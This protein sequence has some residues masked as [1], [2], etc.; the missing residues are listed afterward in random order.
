MPGRDVFENEYAV[1]V[2]E[3]LC[4]VLRTE[5]YPYFHRGFSVRAEYAPAESRG[6][7]HFE[8]QARKIRCHIDVQ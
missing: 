6:W 8:A 2:G 1:V 4:A 3:R 7:D 5:R